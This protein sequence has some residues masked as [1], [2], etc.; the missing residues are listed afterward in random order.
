[1]IT[2]FDIFGIALAMSI[3]AFCVC[4]CIGM[5]Y[6]KPA[7]YMRLGSAFGFFQFL[8]PVLG[9]FAGRV[10]MKY[11]G[12]LKY[13]AAAFLF[14]V[15]FHMAKE[16]YKNKECKVYFSDPT[17]GLSLL[18]LSLATSMDALGSGI[19]LALWDG[20][21]VW[22]SCVIGVVCMLMSFLGVYIGKHSRG[23][24][25]HYAEYFGAF[26]LVVIGARFVL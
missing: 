6:N 15:A 3:D 20:G 17:V 4:I 8:M 21:I 16:A 12:N 23:Y 10:L 11:T 7:N 22:A 25:G 5:K 18:M 9:A 19:S 26:I 1:M 13:L 2:V 24:I 14:Y